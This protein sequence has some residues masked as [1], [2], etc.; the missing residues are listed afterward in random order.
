MPLRP[1]ILFLS[2]IFAKSPM[3]TMKL[4]KKLSLILISQTLPRARQANRYI[5]QTKN[6][7]MMRGLNV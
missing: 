3:Y 6:L 4:V 1:N 7:G 5:N 2:G